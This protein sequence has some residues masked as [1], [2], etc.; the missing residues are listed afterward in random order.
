MKI[1]VTG[2]KGFVGKNLVHTLLNIKD[3]KDRSFDIVVDE[4][5]EYDK[6]SSI[7]DLKK[8]TKDCD[9]VI[10]LAGVNRPKDIKEFYD[11]NK[12][13]IE[14]V[15]DCL[16][17]NNNKCGILV[18]SSIQAS[19]DNDYGKSKKEGEDY[20]KQFSLDSDNPIYIYRFANIFGKWC[21][22]NY[23]SVI[24]TWCYNIT[25]DLDIQVNDES[26]VIPFVYIDDVV[27]EIINC[28]NGKANKKEEFYSAEPIY[29]VSL[30]TLKDTLYSFYDQR[31]SLIIPNLGDEFTKKLYSTYLSY[32]PIEKMKIELKG[33]SDNRG[34]FTEV[35]KSKGFG[36]FS[37][38]ISKPGIT[39]GEHWH[40][41]KWEFF[42][43]VKGRALIEERQID[44]E[45]VI[46]FEVSGDKLEM[47]HMLPGYTHNII[48]LSNDEELITLMWAN[49]L[50]DVNKPDTF[51]LKVNK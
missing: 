9:F 11:G 49:E 25:H 20:L 24:A 3:G 37:V 18:S 36:Q 43:V 47:I 4:V 38:N 12:G 26:A 5:Y 45:E 16:K 8:Y 13:T 44:S 41:T 39:K 33:N 35:L 34:S 1:L 31:Q 32:L 15:C 50:F 46:S 42:L 30:K 28:I 29:N 17:E 7:D 10:H 48:N 14:L 6:E 21:R 23:N 2:S 22:P 27:S 51:S 40:N 19:K